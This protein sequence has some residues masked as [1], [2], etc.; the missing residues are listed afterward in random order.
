MSQDQ[1]TSSAPLPTILVVEPSSTMRA[2]YASHCEGRGASVEYVPDVPAA[3]AW[4]SARKPMAIITVD[5]LEGLNG[6]CLVAALKSSDEHRAIPIVLLEPNEPSSDGLGLYQP[7]HTLVKDSDM[8]ESL[9]NFLDSIGL[10]VRGVV[11]KEGDCES[12]P[13]GTRV[14]LAEDNIVNQTIVG[15]ILHVA[16]A[17]VVAVGDGA[18]A[19][20]EALKQPFDL[21]L[22]DI[23]MPTLDG[24]EATRILRSSGL[25]IPILALTGEEEEEFNKNTGRRGF[26]HALY[27][28]VD[29]SELLSVCREQLRLAESAEEGA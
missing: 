5:E 18:R 12:L 23:Q 1:T 16:G 24:A 25:T 22:M 14:L 7:D 2:V 29:R 27:K 21:I 11:G 17:E 10:G 26:N 20:A 4:V 28:P 6:I 15:H 13:D 19:V 8:H 3:M 9:E